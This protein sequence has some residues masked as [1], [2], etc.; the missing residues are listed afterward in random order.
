MKAISAFLKR[1]FFSVLQLFA[2]KSL[3]L[4]VI[5][6]PSLRFVGFMVMRKAFSGTS[7]LLFECTSPVGFSGTTGRLRVQIIPL[8][9]TD[10][11]I[12]IKM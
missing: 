3:S 11:S 2:D 10:R 12:A 1:A 4:T 6:S 9:D 8:N 7:L 5:K